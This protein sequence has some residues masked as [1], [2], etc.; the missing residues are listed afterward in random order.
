[1]RAEIGKTVKMHRS[2]GSRTVIVPKDWLLW[3]GFQD[4]DTEALLV[5]DEGGIQIRPPHGQLSQPLLAWLDALLE[6]LGPKDVPRLLSQPIPDF[7]LAGDALSLAMQTF[8]QLVIHST[9]PAYLQAT[10]HL[11]L[12]L[13][14]RTDWLKESPKQPWPLGVTMPLNWAAMAVVARARAGAGPK[15]DRLLRP[16]RAIAS[17]KAVWWVPS[18]LARPRAGR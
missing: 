18:S 11:E 4:T 6:G 2:G 3:V 17:G 5:L 12:E 1:M 10:K 13:Q 14:R 15:T 7:N 8:E 16:W 9:H